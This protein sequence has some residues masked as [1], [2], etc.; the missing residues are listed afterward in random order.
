[1][2]VAQA[3]SASTQVFGQGCSH[4]V[5]PTRRSELYYTGRPVLG[6]SVVIHYQAVPWGSRSVTTTGYLFWGLS[7]SSVMGGPLPIP[8]WHFGLPFGSPNCLIYTSSDLHSGMV[9][10][11]LDGRITIP[12]PNE[13]HLAGMTIYQQWV[14]RYSVDLN[15][16]INT[17]FYLTNGGSLTFGY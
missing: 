12:I 2:V 10:G 17:N 11:Q 15:G 16:S 9:S 8:A 5:E 3:Q 7:N 4:P 13:P 6:S 14:L 1:M